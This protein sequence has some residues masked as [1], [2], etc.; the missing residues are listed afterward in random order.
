[1]ESP[2]HVRSIAAKRLVQKR[3]LRGSVAQTEIRKMFRLPNKDGDIEQACSS[4][5][6]RTRGQAGPVVEYIR[7]HGLKGSGPRTRPHAGPEGS[8]RSRRLR[9]LKS[10]TLKRKAGRAAG[11]PAPSTFEEEVDFGG[12]PAKE[13]SPE[14]DQDLR[15]ERPRRKRRKVRAS[16]LGRTAVRESSIRLV[17]RSVAREMPLVLKENRDR[18]V[19]PEKGPLTLRENLDQY[20]GPVAVVHPKKHPWGSWVCEYCREVNGPEESACT[21]CGDD[22]HNSTEWADDLNT[23][24][25]RKAK[26]REKERHA[27]LLER[28]LRVARWYCIRCGNANLMSRV[29]CFRCSTAKPR[30]E[31]Q[32]DDSSDDSDRDRR[33]AATLRNLPEPRKRKRGGR[34][35]KK[36]VC[37]C[38]RDRRPRGHKVPRTTSGLKF[39]D[40]LRLAARKAIRSF[41]WK[42]KLRNKLQHILNGNGFSTELVVKVLVAASFVPLAWKAEEEAENLLESVSNLAIRVVEEVEEGTAS[43]VYTTGLVAST[44]VWTAGAVLLWWVSRIVLNRLARMTHGNTTKMPCRLIELK[45]GE[46][47]WEVAGSK[48]KHRVWINQGQS[49]CACRS[50]IEEG[51]CGHIQTALDQAKMM[52]IGSDSRTVKF[53]EPSIA[54]AKGIAALRSSDTACFGGVVRKAQSIARGSECFRGLS[55]AGSES[56]LPV[57][58]KKNQ[59][60]STPAVRKDAVKA[61]EEALKIEGV[62]PSAICEIKFLKDDIALKVFCEL[63]SGLTAGGQVFLRAYS[64][65]QPDVVRVLLDSS[66]R[67]VRVSLICDQGQTGG[68]TKAQLQCLKQLQ[69]SGVRVK[70]CRGKSVQAAY[71]NDNRNVSVGSGLRGLHHAKTGLVIRPEKADMILSSC[72]YTTSSRAYR[73]AGVWITANRQDSV[74]E[75]WITAWEELWEQGSSI[76]DFEGASASSKAGKPRA[77]EQ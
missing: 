38:G 55:G 31:R 6:E 37:R 69:A 49:A 28:A 18:P 56:T 22:F 71:K 67:S 66:N 42:R 8:R 54:A 60:G 33:I 47:T 21:A 15:G 14:E 13:E 74:I 16:D 5:D 35:H 65:D 64:C 2:F 72:N 62:G 11:K 76:E 43:V 23:P 34:K 70:L 10:S 51:S 24:V 7:R 50:Y 41:Y 29:K 30:K 17:L 59:G 46:S 75:D 39:E 32:D 73:E 52:G 27:S 57:E 12:S 48:S 53:N 26:A 58:D 45:A 1:M 20:D 3:R 9:I 77:V 61:Q 68:R 63:V 44:L 40:C 36:K 4:C 19:S 25:K